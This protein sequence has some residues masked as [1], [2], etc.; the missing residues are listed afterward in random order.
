LLP[1]LPDPALQISANYL[2][3]KFFVDMAS[4]LA[5][6]RTAGEVFRARDTDK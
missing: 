5:A 4:N 2:K 1:N 3:V 6:R